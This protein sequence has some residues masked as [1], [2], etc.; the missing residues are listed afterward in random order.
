[1]YDLVILAN[2]MSRLWRSSSTATFPS[3]TLPELLR[4]S[5]KLFSSATSLFSRAANRSST[6][7]FFSGSAFF[8]GILTCF[9]L[10]ISRR[11]ESFPAETTSLFIPAPPD[12]ITPIAARAA[13][14][15]AAE[16]NAVTR[17]NL[18]PRFSGAWHEASF[19]LFKPGTL[20]RIALVDCRLATVHHNSHLLKIFCSEILRIR[21]GALSKNMQ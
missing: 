16:V 2:S 13:N 21:R 12:C 7:I 17:E 9:V 20:R 10:A 15:T 19:F 4:E 3:S 1:M 6:G 18:L 14:S 8:S 5:G 11:A